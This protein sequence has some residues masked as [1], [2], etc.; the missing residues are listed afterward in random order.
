MESD[1]KYIRRP[2]PADDAI[3]PEGYDEWPHM[4]TYIPRIA[5]DLWVQTCTQSL[6]A[7]LYAHHHDLPGRDSFIL[8]FL[9][10]PRLLLRRVASQAHADKKLAKVLSQYV[11]HGRLPLPSS[12]P[13]PSG[14]R[15][16]NARRINAA[17][18]KVKGG[19]VRKAVDALLQPGALE[20]T[21]ETLD[22]LQA[23]HPD[24]SEAISAADIQHAAAQAKRWLN[25]KDVGKRPD[26][27]Y[28]NGSAPGPSGWTG[29]MLRPLLDSEICRKGLALIFSLIM[30]GDIRTPAARDALRAA[31]LIPVPKGAAAAGV[32]PIAVGELFA[33]VGS[34]FA[35]SEVDLA[36]VFDDDIQ[37][38]LGVRSGVERAVLTVQALLDA[39]TTT[40]DTVVI[41]TDIRNA[42]NTVHRSRIM[43][44][45]R[46]NP[47]TRHLCPL[48]EWSHNG[49]SKLLVYKD[50]KL[51]ST[52]M[53]A[54]G[55][56]QGHPLGSLCFDLAIHSDYQA[57]QEAFRARGVRLIAI[58]DDLTIV[59]PAA[60]A[61]DAFDMFAKLLTDRGDLQLRPDKCRVLIPAKAAP[62]ATNI[63]HLAATRRVSVVYG[64]M[65]LHG[66][67]IG[68]DETKMRQAI[69][70]TVSR[71]DAVLEAV[72]DPLM[73]SQTAWCIIRQCVVSSVGFYIRITQPHIAH[74]AIKEFDLKVIKAISASHSLPP[75]LDS[76]NDRKLLLAA[77]GIAES[78]AISPIA[79]L[80]CL[81][82]CL[83]HLPE[84]AKDGSTY[85]ALAAAHTSV[86]SPSSSL[87]VSSR[88]PLSLDATVRQ[89]SKTDAN[90]V[91]QLQR[92]VTSKLKASARLDID[93]NHRKDEM[94]KHM[95][96][97]LNSTDS[98]HANLIFRILPTDNSLSLK[99]NDWDQLLRARLA[100]PPNDNLPP[101]CPHCHSELLTEFAKTHHHQSCQRMMPLRTKRHNAVLNV[102]LALA[103]RAGHG[104]SITNQNWKHTPMPKELLALK[105][106]ASILPG[107]AR[108]ANILL[109]VGVTHPCAEAHLHRA[110]K[111]PLSAAQ[112]MLN[113]KHKTYRALT[114]KIDYVF[115]GAIMETYGAMAE[116]FRKLVESLVQDVMR[117]EGLSLT[118]AKQL[119]IHTFASLSVALHRGN[120]MLARS[121]F[122]VSSVD[123]DSVEDSSLPRLV[124]G[125]Q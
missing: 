110:A 100:Y 125:A 55:V 98:K 117:N 57:V 45:L 27:F 51:L 76:D 16:D 59:G 36:E 81:L 35:L 49:P 102:V 20:I 66:G 112:A 32:R 78:S 41:S 64:A 54:D 37:L 2:S 68:T 24:A 80:C 65:S 71:F 25:S 121:M 11:Q 17:H 48:F 120:A 106:D 85:A 23:L 62:H 116:E 113:E 8:K 19:F 95:R 28:D 29:A 56:Q 42:F 18:R 90:N 99:S 58:H 88:I 21:V 93:T 31:R 101:R 50:R 104:T 67:C 38:G 39:R 109:D 40:P 107:I 7:L 114:A 123:D 52:I 46:D 83:P 86:A 70:D 108:R 119:Q 26:R 14:L 44:A 122:C 84:L 72:A 82:T 33:R 53:S 47:A 79:Y 74:D 96:A 77:L 91:S 105:P 92:F 6:D 89:F 73:P 103:R 118:Q 34:V 87:D 111:A 97:I 124:V 94:A 3:L 12:A 63:E 115:V 10:L 69:K 4:F 9:S 60:A 22:Q 43:K 75:G 30:N 5:K 15:S 61:F 13:A 1:H